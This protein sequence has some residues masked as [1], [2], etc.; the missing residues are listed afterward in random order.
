MPN[1]AQQT[2]IELN[3]DHKNAIGEICNFITAA[4]ASVIGNQIGKNIERTPPQV[5]FTLWQ[6]FQAEYPSSLLLAEATLTTGLKGKILLFAA[7]EKA[8]K[9]A[10]LL[11]GKDNGQAAALKEEELGVL[12]GVLDKALSESL[13]NISATFGQEASGSI[14]QVKV[15]TIKDEIKSLSARSSEDSLL[16]VSSSLIASDALLEIQLEY[17]LPVDFAEEALS[18]IA[19]DSGSAASSGETETKA[20]VASGFQATGVAAPDE[21][22]Q[23]TEAVQPAQ[24]ASLAPEGV[25]GATNN[26]ELLLDIALDASIELGRTQMSVKEIL[27]LGGGSVIELEKAAG[28]TV[29]FLVNGKIIARGEVVVIEGKFGIRITEIVSPRERLESV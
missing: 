25:A 2:K 20:E 14:T 13:T 28:E 27:D 3:D 24:F 9:L 19:S 21:V 5:S 15:I 11:Q 26:I 8:A 7:E 29:D 16:R 17:I 1:E 6:Q 22:S 12:K 23:A 4:I 10:D 18:A